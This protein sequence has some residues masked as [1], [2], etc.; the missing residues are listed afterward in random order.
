MFVSVLHTYIGVGVYNILCTL[1]WLQFCVLQFFQ[2]L[3]QWLYSCAQMKS[4][5]GELY[6][7]VLQFVPDLIKIY[8]QG[9]YE[10]NTQVKKWEG[11]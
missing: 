6:T 9:I 4:Q 3:F 8:L 2:A 1:M 10:N 11:I 7:F 5:S